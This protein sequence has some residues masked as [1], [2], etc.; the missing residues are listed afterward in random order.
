MREYRVVEEPVSPHDQTVRACGRCGGPLRWRYQVGAAWDR[1]L[2][3]CSEHGLRAGWIVI[4][5]DGRRLLAI[6]KVDN[7]GRVLRTPRDLGSHPLRPRRARNDQ[8]HWKKRDH[9]QRTLLG[10]EAH[11]TEFIGPQAW[12]GDLGPFVPMAPDA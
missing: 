2:P 6:A 11:D 1:G 3:V 10:I 9:G 5:R 4:S 7:K 12:P 8:H